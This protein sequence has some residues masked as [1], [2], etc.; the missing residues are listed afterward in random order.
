[1]SNLNMKYGS[2]RDDGK[3]QLC[4]FMSSVSNEK[5]THVDEGGKVK[6][7]NITSK[8]SSH[9]I[10][11]ASSRVVVGKDILDVVKNNAM[12]KGDVLTI[13]KLA[14]IM[15][16]KKTHHLIPLC[17][18]ISVA[19]VDIEMSFDEENSAINVISKVSSTGQTGVEMEALTAVS[20]ASLTIYDMCKSLSHHIVIENIRLIR[21]SGGKSD[22]YIKTKN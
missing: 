21:K 4:R 7:V 1:M 18:S 16:A 6:M 9:R 13:A 8:A 12:K 3:L 17:H 20:V 10:A 5:L 2:K 14:G 19:G 22:Y 11:V 15:A